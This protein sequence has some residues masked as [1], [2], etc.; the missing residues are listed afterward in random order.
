VRDRH[1]QDGWEE[2]G[3]FLDLGGEVTTKM[4]LLRPIPVD[5]HQF[6]H[7]FSHDPWPQ[8]GLHKIIDLSGS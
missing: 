2:Q 3:P 7:E 8:V 5:D 1:C 4:K 6:S